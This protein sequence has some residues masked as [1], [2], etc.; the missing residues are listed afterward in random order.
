M[1]QSACML[2]REPHNSPR[3]Y[4]TGFSGLFVMGVSADDGPK[5]RVSYLDRVTCESKTFSKDLCWMQPAIKE[6]IE[7]Y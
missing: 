4:C 7:Q 3:P 6:E 1:S 5:M 2:P